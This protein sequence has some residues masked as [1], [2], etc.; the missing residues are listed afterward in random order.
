M[1]MAL[2]SAA[3]AIEKN[4]CKSEMVALKYEAFEYCCRFRQ[5]EF[6]FEIVA[7]CLQCMPPILPVVD[8]WMGQHQPMQWALM[9]RA[10]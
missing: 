7:L 10:A 6:E 2:W 5:N 3:G 1:K 9:A 4:P 8:A